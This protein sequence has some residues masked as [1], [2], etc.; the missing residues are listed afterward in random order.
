MD[1]GLLWPLLGVA[2]IGG[3]LSTHMANRRMLRM[4]QFFSRQHVMSMTALADAAIETM[5][6][7]YG[8]DMRDAL[9]AMM[10]RAQLRNPNLIGIPVPPTGEAFKRAE[11][12]VAKKRA[13]KAAKEQTGVDT[14]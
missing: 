12:Y 11:A 1:T 8:A 10:D 9:K 5:A 13:E 3:A 14:K 7:D 6:V 4:R 2:L